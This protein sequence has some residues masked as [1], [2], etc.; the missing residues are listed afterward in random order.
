MIELLLQAE[1]ALS[2]GL[3]DHA[4]RLYRQAVAADPLNSIAVVGLARVAL[5]HADD[6]EAYRRA[7]QALRIDPENVAAVRLVER[8]EEV[9]SHRGQALP[10][11]ERAGPTRPSPPAIRPM[12]V[13]QPAPGINPAPA[14]VPVPVSDTTDSHIIARVTMSDTVDMPQAVGDTPLVT[15]TRVAP[16]APIESPR[17]DAPTP[18]LVAPDVIRPIA[19]AAGPGPERVGAPP[20]PLRDEPARR[21]VLG[22][23]VDRLLGRKRP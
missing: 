19:P 22:R 1:R 17:S 23:L 11:L 9:F 7:R 2:I 4:E 13:A 12:P 10:T 16:A 5:E 15:P 8:L 14:P 3:V 20:A 6:A 21:G 18:Q